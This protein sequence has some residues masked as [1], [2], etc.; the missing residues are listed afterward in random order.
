MPS[1]RTI[2][3]TAAQPTRVGPVAI[4]PTIQIKHPTA[5]KP[6]IINLEDF[7][8]ATMVR[9]EDYLARRAAEQNAKATEAA[10]KA[11]ENKSPKKKR[12]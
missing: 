4:L 5:E 6:V 7:D 3:V 9:W 11:A 10:A 12:R 8:P 1:I 2:P